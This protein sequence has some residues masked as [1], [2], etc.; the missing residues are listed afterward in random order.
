MI[1]FYIYLLLYLSC[2]FK[3]GSENE[4]NSFLNM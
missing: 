1:K 3:G 4:C 2:D